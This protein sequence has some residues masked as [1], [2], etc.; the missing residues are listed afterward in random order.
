VRL[1]IGAIRVLASLSQV[2]TS[3]SPFVRENFA[4]MGH[5]EKEK[6]GGQFATI[7][8]LHHAIFPLDCLGKWNT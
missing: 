3:I 6:D 1:G 4:G 7:N 5:F 8:D 2:V